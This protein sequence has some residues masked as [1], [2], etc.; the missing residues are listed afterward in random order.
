L[1]AGGTLNLTSYEVNDLNPGGYYF[2]VVVADEAG[3]KAAY[4]AKFVEL[5]TINNLL[6]NN[7]KIYPNPSRGILE[8]EWTDMILDEITIYNAMGTVIY[9]F[10][11]INSSFF[12]FNTQSLSSG[13]YFISVK[14]Q[15]GI[16]SSK[17]IVE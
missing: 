3:N 6:K 12:K 5:L 9:S 14:T 10:S 17:F 4:T 1:N 15:E 16:L 11:N 2:N 8:V 13:L 7:L